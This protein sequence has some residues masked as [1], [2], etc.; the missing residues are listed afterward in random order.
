[1]PNP[2]LLSVFLLVILLALGCKRDANDGAGGFDPEIYRNQ[3]NAAILLDK[4]GDLVKDY[5]D[6]GFSVN[7]ALLQAQLRI[8]QEPGV[9]S[10]FHYD[11]TYL[12]MDLSSGLRAVFNLVEQDSTDH[13]RFRGAGSY[14]E[15]GE[16]SS[17]VSA[18]CKDMEQRNVLLYHPY[19]DL[20][21][22]TMGA[23]KLQKA[24]DD[25]VIDDYRRA[26]YKDCTY[27]VLNSFKDYG[28]VILSTHGLPDGFLMGPFATNFRDE[29]GEVR[30]F[31]SV[32]KDLNNTQTIELTSQMNKGLLIL[33]MGLKYKSGSNGKATWVNRST[34]EDYSYAISG[35]LIAEW[36]LSE[37]VLAALMCYGG[38]QA[39]LTDPRPGDISIVEAFRLAKT[40]S[41]YGFQINGGTS[42]AVSDSIARA[43]EGKL[44][45]GLLVDFDCTGEANLDE[46]GNEYYDKAY[47]NTSWSKNWFRHFFAEDYTFDPCG[48]GKFTDARDQQEY[49]TACIGDQIW[50]AENLNWAGAGECY[51][52]SNANC[53]VFGRLYSLDEVTGKQA[54]SPGNPVQGICPDGWHVPSKDEVQEL[55][56]FLGGKAY[57]GDSL[58]AD[59]I[60]PGSYLDNYGFAALPGGRK[61]EVGSGNVIE[62]WGLG[63]VYE[64]WT[65]TVESGAD[66]YVIANMSTNG[67]AFQMGNMNPDRTDKRKLACRCVKD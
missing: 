19:D 31:E 57:A 17:V 60:W 46:S 14:S 27:E 41:Y 67:P 40:R 30:P 61:Q 8:E 26:L 12:Y 3:Y 63:L 50:M 54:S 34:A 9:E 16:I 21:P 44:Y 24:K 53:E 11:S 52:N 7:E 10:T 6:S 2:R 4:V 48:V 58:K 36:D 38:W 25:G 33:Q 15:F 66:P 5:H 55:I 59:T 32:A 43:V 65:S 23:A 35:K 42:R 39:P 22:N 18:G 62:F 20:I 56:D 51:D 13:S 64:F 47:Y 1:M 29:Q 45:D 49:K 28:L 37:T